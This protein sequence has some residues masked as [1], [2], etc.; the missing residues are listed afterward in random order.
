MKQKYVCT[1]CYLQNEKTFTHPVQN[2]GVN[3]PNDFFPK[4][5]AQGAWTRCLKCQARFGKP[6]PHGAVSCGTQSRQDQDHNITSGDI[7]KTCAEKFPNVAVAC[8]NHVC[9]VCE[10]TFSQTH[11]STDTMKKHRY[12]H[13]LLVCENCKEKGCTVLNKTLYKCAECEKDWVLLNDAG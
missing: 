13:T 7:C 9:S 6:K 2:F 8:S 12:R 10:K 4:Y 11:W 5:M 1:S 3:T